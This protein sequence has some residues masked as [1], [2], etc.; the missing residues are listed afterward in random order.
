VDLAKSLVKTSMRIFTCEVGTVK[1][2]PIDDETAI[3]AYC[4]GKS[5]KEI[6]IACKA[7]YK[8]IYRWRKKKGLPSNVPQGRPRKEPVL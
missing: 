2:Y 5:D 7:H 8:S 1:N 3:R 6:A 4:E